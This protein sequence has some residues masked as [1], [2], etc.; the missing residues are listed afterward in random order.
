MRK[1][2]A[3]LHKP[4]EY[5]EIEENHEEEEQRGKDNNSDGR[6]R[7]TWT[8]TAWNNRIPDGINNRTLLAFVRFTA[9]RTGALGIT[10]L[11]HD[12]STMR[13]KFTIL[14]EDNFVSAN[15]AVVT[16]DFHAV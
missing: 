7:R 1:G 16:S 12:H 2:T 5:E 15:R 6:L 3:P 11:M 10:N 13:T 14:C 9:S 8:Q 4:E